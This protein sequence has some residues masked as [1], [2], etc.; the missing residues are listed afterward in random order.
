MAYDRQRFHMGLADGP[1]RGPQGRRW[2]ARCSRR[3]RPTD[4]LFPTAHI[5][6]RREAALAKYADV[7]S[8]GGS[9]G[10]S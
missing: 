6:A 7:L 2:P 8:V 3:R 4:G 10:G 9:E 1:D 5:P